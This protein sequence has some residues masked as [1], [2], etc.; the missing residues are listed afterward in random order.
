VL[1]FVALVPWLW[2]LDRSGRWPARWLAALAMTLA[3]AVR[4]SSGSAW[5]SG[6]S[7]AWGPRPVLALLLLLAP[8][9]QPQVLVWALL[10][11]GWAAPRPGLG[12][13]AGAAGWVGT[14]WLLLK[15]LGDTLGHGLYPS[16]LLRQAAT[17]AAPP[18]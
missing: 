5:P 18:G 7:P 15:P 3:L 17:W 8:L 11:R 4:S 1:G 12:A 13:L 6:A 9:L 14:E 2:V 16:T 10:R